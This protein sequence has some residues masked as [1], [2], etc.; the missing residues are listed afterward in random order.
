MKWRIQV[1][2]IRSSTMTGPSNHV[3]GHEHKE[4]EVVINGTAYITEARELTG[5]ELK[6]LGHVPANETLFLKRGNE[7]VRIGDDEVVK[8]HDGMQ[9]ESAP[10]GGVS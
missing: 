5:A 2:R 10:D 3:E 1:R 7:E 6:A 4:I 9:F 8:L